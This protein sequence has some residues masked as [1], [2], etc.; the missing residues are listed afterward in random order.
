MFSFHINYL[1]VIE[2]PVLHAPNPS[3][4]PS[5]NLFKADDVPWLG[6]EV[7]ISKSKHPSKGSRWVVRN[8]LRGQQTT[9]G[10]RVEIVP[11]NYDPSLPFPRN[12]VDYDE[13]VEA[14]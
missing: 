11:M 10:L 4:G 9:S 12:V 6:A 1:K 5:A 2:P 7:I 8:V 14:R 3:S 13:V